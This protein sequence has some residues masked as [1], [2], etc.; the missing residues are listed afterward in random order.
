[1]KILRLK[2][3]I[4]LLTG[5]HIGAGDDSMKIG[6]LDNPV[7][8]DV[9]TNEPY[10]PGS[11]LKGKMRSLLEHK[12]GVVGE[13]GEPLDGEKLGELE[14]ISE[15]KRAQAKT[16]LKVFGD[17]S[18]KSGITRASFGD[19]PLLKENKEDVTDEERVLLEVKWETFIDR[20]TGSAKHPRQTERVAKG[21]KFIY[22][23]R[24]KVFPGDEEEEFKKLIK[25]GI[26]LIQ[27]DYLGGNGSR[28]YGRVRFSNH[29]K[30][31]EIK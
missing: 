25:E 9:N 22:D 18:G 13:D 17:K 14:H 26:K 30:W 21:I 19:C 27:A 11:S 24:I 12:L 4:E 3:E 8:K 31:E 16:L 29:D 2:G 10:I 23:I 6:G 7:I 1:M 15:E 28:G 5:L 20:G